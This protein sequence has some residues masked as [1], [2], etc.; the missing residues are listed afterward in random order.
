MKRIFTRR[1]TKS[2]FV[3][4]MTILTNGNTKLGY[5]NPEIGLRI[6]DFY[7]WRDWFGYGE[8]DDGPKMIYC[9]I[10]AENEAA[11]QWLTK[12]G[13]IEKF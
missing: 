4:L 6:S 11:A 1:M 2:E 7:G 3:E 8:W 10:D 5:R 12:H 13:F 9:F